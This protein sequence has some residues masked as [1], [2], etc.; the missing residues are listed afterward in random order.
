MM[1]AELPVVS[2]KSSERLL[3][4]EEVLPDPSLDSKTLLVAL[5]RN[6]D[7][8]VDR[9]ERCELSSKEVLDQGREHVRGG[10]RR[11]PVVGKERGEGKQREA[12]SV[13]VQC[14]SSVSCPPR[15]SS[16]SDRHKE[17]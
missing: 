16:I 4:E 15:P 17:E 11:V 2:R 9:R 5:S 8:D 12:V 14:K 10:C 6:V 3:T 7:G 1:R 13:C